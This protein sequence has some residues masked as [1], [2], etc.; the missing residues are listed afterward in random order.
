MLVV[1]AFLCLDKEEYDHDPENPF[2]QIDVSNKI[3]DEE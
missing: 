1:M 2:D 3:Q